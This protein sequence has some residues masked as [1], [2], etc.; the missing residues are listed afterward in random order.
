MAMSLYNF[1]AKCQYNCTGMF[2]GA[3]SIIVLGMFYDA[4]YT[5]HTANKQLG[6]KSL[7]N[8]YMKNV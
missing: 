4:R 6:K 5:H 8:K 2:Y 7:K 1:I 3:N